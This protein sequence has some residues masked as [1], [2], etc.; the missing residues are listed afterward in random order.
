MRFFSRALQISG[1]CDWYTHYRKY[2]ISLSESNRDSDRALFLLQF[3]IRNTQPLVSFML[4]S[5]QHLT[6]LATTTISDQPHTC[7][8]N[9]QV[10]TPALNTEAST[11]STT[12]TSTTST[13][14]TSTTPTSTTSTSTT[15]TI[16]PTSTVLSPLVP[17][18]LLPLALLP[19]ALLPALLPST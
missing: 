15:T 13:I 12:P 6:L 18:A 4:V 9:E 16:I 1:L 2:Y 3:F 10:T 14:P 8:T 19:P 7:T 11:T 17:Q 5:P